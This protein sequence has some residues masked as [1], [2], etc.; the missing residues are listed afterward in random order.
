MVSV[1]KNEVLTETAE[2][3]V[4]IFSLN[5]P[6]RHN[7][8]NLNLAESLV[9]ALER[10]ETDGETKVVVVTGSGD[11]AFCAGQ[12]MLEASGIEPGRA[13]PK[14]SSAYLAIDR[15]AASP[16]PLIAAINGYCYG[17]GAALA[18]ACDIRIS[19]ER[20][21][22]RLP[23]AEYGLV[24]GAASLPRLV[25]AARAK[26]IIL[27]ARRFDSEQAGDWGMVNY[28]VPDNSVLSKSLEMAEAIAA[29]SVIAVRESKRVIDLAT[30]VEEAVSNENEINRKL[31]GSEEQSDR[32]RSAT[33]K[34]TGR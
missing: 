8:I 6:E 10:A 26:E 24:V 5:R 25:G 4:K 28:V 30:M 13:D 7:A 17:G 12:D 9:A 2:G 1:E 15:F 14:S 23:G 32:F 31:R 22:F 33:K 34:V 16:L 21:T 18:L 11:K 29:N 27:T 3:A 20:A 19:A